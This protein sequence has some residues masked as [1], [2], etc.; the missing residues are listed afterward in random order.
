MK[1]IKRGSVKAEETKKI[2]C[3]KCTSVLEYELK[4]IQMDREGKYIVC[5][6]CGQF[7]AV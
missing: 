5:P 2:M 7:L 6:V 1:I 4:D 3:G